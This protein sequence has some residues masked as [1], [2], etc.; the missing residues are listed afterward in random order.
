MKRPVF[1]A[2]PTPHLPELA[3]R[4][5]DVFPNLKERIVVP[6]SAFSFR[7]KGDTRI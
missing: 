1:P 2:V 4:L 6:G 3:R 7:N 5:D